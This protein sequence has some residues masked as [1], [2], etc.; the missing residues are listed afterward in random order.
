MDRGRRN[1]IWA[2]LIPIPT[3]KDGQ[4]RNFYDM[5]K[6]YLFETVKKGDNVWS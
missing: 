1:L 3:R 5:R 4:E 2:V 6:E